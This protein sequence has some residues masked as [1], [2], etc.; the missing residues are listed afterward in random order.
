MQQVRGT[1][2]KGLP[3][4]IFLVLGAVIYI[5]A[6]NGP[7]LFDDESFI[8]KN[9][10]IKDATNF[11]LIGRSILAHHSR[12]VAFYSFALN[13]HFHQFR[14]FGYHLINFLIHISATS[15]VWWFVRLIFLKP[16]V[17]SL[18]DSLLWQHVFI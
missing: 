7:F 16:S 8:L 17:I 5:H 2:V 13:Y 15:L 9:Q 11:N 18:S 6:F 10:T 3:F 12:F 1:L 14:V 4:V